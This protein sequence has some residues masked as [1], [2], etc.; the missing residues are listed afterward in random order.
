MTRRGTSGIELERVQVLVRAARQRLN[1]PLEQVA[2]E[3]AA[4]AAGLEAE[5]SALAVRRDRLQ[6]LADKECID[7][8]ARKLALATRN[9]RAQWR[10]AWRLLASIALVSGAA[11]AG[12]AMEATGFPAG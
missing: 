5:V 3:V 12:V 6:R 7:S 1:V 2:V 9:E 10:A 8:L 11:L 4:A